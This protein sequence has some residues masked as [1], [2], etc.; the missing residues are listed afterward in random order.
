MLDTQKSNL[1]AVSEKY[2]LQSPQWAE[3]WLDANLPGHHFYNLRS[4]NKLDE[5]I[6]V[7]IYQYP[8]HFG[9]NFL[10]IP[11]GPFL[12]ISDKIEKQTLELLLDNLFTQIL[13]LAK[14]QGSSFIK[15]ELDDIVSQILELKTNSD[16]EGYSSSLLKHQNRISEKKLQYLETILVETK[17]LKYEADLRQFFE[18]NTDFWTKVNKKTRYGTRKSLEQNWKISTEKTQVNFE[19]F[20]NLTQET[21]LRQGFATQSKDYFQTL[22]TKDFSYLTILKKDNEPQAAWFGVKLGNS[23]IHLYG[24]NTQVSRENYGQYFAHLVALQMS[25]KSSIA[26]YDLGGWDEVKGYGKFK[27]G[28]NGKIR[29]FLGPVDIIIDKFS[30]NMINLATKIRKIAK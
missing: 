25:A 10:Y 11:K 16:F 4:S 5:E 14:K 12:E 18:I 13:E 28:Y 20:W 22:F 8:W 21:A 9:A 2:F 19:I 30:Y 15:W 24:A 1:S 7:I 23:L 27:E 6:A 3:F 29:E 26:F 17:N